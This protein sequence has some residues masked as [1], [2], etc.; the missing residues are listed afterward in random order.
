M[1]STPSIG[2][3]KYFVTFINDFSRYCYVYLLHTKDETM[4]K[5]KIYRK[6]IEL[7]CEL[8]IKCLRSDRGGEYYDPKYFESTGIIHEITTPYTPK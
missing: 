6:E 4:E 7:Y 8:L 5:F 2:R 1:H 3:K